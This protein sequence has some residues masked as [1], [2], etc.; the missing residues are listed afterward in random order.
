MDNQFRTPKV[1]ILPATLLVGMG[2]LVTACNVHTGQ[3]AS[4]GIGFRETRFAQISAMRSYR[5]CRDDAVKLDTKAREDGSN[6]RYLASAKLFEKCEQQ[7]GPD[8]VNVATEERLRAYAISI[9]N[10]FRGG[11]IS[12]ARANLQSFK[13]TFPDKDLLF[14]DGSSFVDTME[15]LL[16]MNDRAA[17]GQFSTL[18]ASQ[19]L[20]SE[21]RRVNYWKNN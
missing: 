13:Q 15:V 18:N 17:L 3:S 11:N 10:Y 5:Q 1:G 12:K 14:S 7:V 9:L 4:E 8:A 6:S 19:Q 20:K 16:S 2:L 21:L